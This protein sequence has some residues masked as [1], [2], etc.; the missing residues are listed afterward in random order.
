MK[1]LLIIFAIV[2][3]VVGGWL[4]LRPGKNDDSSSHKTPKQAEQKPFNKTEHSL[5][6]PA[7]IWTIVNKRRPLNPK[8][9]VPADLVA[10]KV[11]LRLNAE[12]QEMLMRKEVASSLELMFA[13]AKKAGLELMVASAYRPYTLQENLYNRYVAQQGQLAADT[14]SARPG[15]SEHQTGLA[16]DVEPASQNCEVELCF[17]DTPEGKWVAENAHTYGFVLR[18]HEDKDD[19]TG[20]MYE[21][22]HLRY[23]G[24][25]LA[26]ELHRQS[27]PTLEQF[28][29]LDPAPDYKP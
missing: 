1:K 3:L 22:W 29:E 9:Y 15:H 25:P 6:D 26:D 20:Y 21:P 17:A 11:T 27:D 19:V 18:Y 14:Q 13:D 5:D 28:F 24:K 23:V 12:E 8:T 2:V 10:P 16:V 7:S 4:V